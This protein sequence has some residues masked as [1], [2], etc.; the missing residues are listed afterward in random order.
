MKWN[1]AAAFL[2]LLLV[3]QLFSFAPAIL[4]RGEDPTPVL[5]TTVC[6]LTGHPSHFDGKMVRVKV[7]FVSPYR[8]MEIKD[9]DNQCPDT[10]P[11]SYSTTAPTASSPPRASTSTRALPPPTLIDDQFDLFKKYSIAR[12]YPRTE[13]DP[14]RPCNRYEITATLI[15]MVNFPVR[16][17]LDGPRYVRTFFL[18]SMTNVKA[19]DI[20][21]SYEPKQYS[22]EPVVYPR[23]HIT[24]ELLDPDGNPLPIANL[25]ISS[26]EDPSPNGYD[27][28]NTD[29]HGQFSFSVPPGSYIL[30][31]NLFAGPSANLPY[32]TTY[33]PC[34]TDKASAKVFHLKADQHVDHVT[35]SLAGAKRLPE[36][37]FSGK[38]IWPDG[39]AASDAFVQLTQVIMHG[40]SPFR[41]ASASSDANGNFSM[42]GFEGKDY[43]IHA[44]TAV[45]YNPASASG[46]ETACAKKVRLDSI[47]PSTAIELKL[48][49]SGTFPCN[50]Q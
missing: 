7:R 35:F 8:G 6:E 50:Q 41:T 43:F 16:I 15:G 10:I 30:T 36:R 20:S 13:G 22:T 33:F 48:T 29:D 19:R 5:D 42:N 12:M 1:F 17:P 18:Q 46:K 38:V 24:G 21:A 25:Q 27:N 44:K 28:Q 11:L 14:C 2:S 4:I 34:T 40:D 47:E 9:A 26:T 45:D 23:A 31:I 32:D 49:V 37:K 39:R 3:Q